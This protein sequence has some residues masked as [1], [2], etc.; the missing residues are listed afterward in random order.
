VKQEQF[1]DMPKGFRGWL[2]SFVESHSDTNGS[3][4]RDSMRELLIQ[5]FPPEYDTDLV[6]LINND[7]WI[8]CVAGLRAI[9]VRLIDQVALNDASPA[10]AK[11]SRAAVQLMLP[12]E[13]FVNM[14]KGRYAKVK[15]STAAIERDIAAYI[16]ANPTVGLTVKQIMAMV[17]KSA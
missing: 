17:R 10:F 16:E 15:V 9:G 1:P 8:K 4:D 14:L 6:T 2:K 11:S 12:L 3:F 13:D 7:R 5:E